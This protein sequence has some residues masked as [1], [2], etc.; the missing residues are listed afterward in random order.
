MTHFQVILGF[1][2]PSCN[3]WLCFCL[4]SSETPLLFCGGLLLQLPPSV[5]L[6]EPSS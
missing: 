1:S 6:T 5:D 2:S 3:L 4:I